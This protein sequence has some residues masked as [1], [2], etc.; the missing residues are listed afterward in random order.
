MCTSPRH[1]IV[2]GKHFGTRSG[3]YV[4]P[5]G[6]C[7][8]CI[9]KKQNMWMIRLVEQMKSSKK[10]VFI[11]LTYD[12]AHVP[13]SVDLDNG[14]V[15]YTLSKRHVQLWLKRL[16]TRLSRRGFDFEGNKFAYFAVG[17][18][19]MHP[20]SRNGLPAR[21]RVSSEETK[22]YRPHYHLLIFGVDESDVRFDFEQWRK[23]F[24]IISTMETVRKPGGCAKYVSKYV[25]K[26][27]FESEYVRAGKVAPSFHLCSHG[28]GVEYVERMRDF[29][30][31]CPLGVTKK[32][33]N[34]SFYGFTYYSE[35]YLEVVTDNLVYRDPNFVNK[36]SGEICRFALPRYYKERILGHIIYLP[37]ARPGKTK[38]VVCKSTLSR[39]VAEFLYK[40]RLAGCQSELQ[41]LESL[42]PDLSIVDLC[43]LYDDQESKKIEL[44]RLAAD[45]RLARWY[46]CHSKI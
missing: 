28:L 26:G 12:D 14:D 16:K 1:I 10:G 2:K 33:E 40:K 25:A 43:R 19:G 46:K 23:H 6:E 27:S 11:T 21:P 7:S 32:I 37:S 17:E 30:R 15:L 35:R 31:C 34:G 24:G 42:F 45:E 9:I 3:S 18:Y 38:K 13:L 5:C 36:S 41:R 20:G 39:E 22:F 29:H 8:E 4:V 44:R